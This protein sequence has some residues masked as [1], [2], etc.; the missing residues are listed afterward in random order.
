MIIKKYLSLKICILLVIITVLPLPGIEA[1]KFN[2]LY[3]ELGNKKTAVVMQQHVNVQNKTKF[4]NIK[5]INLKV[6]PYR[7][8]IVN[9][10][11]KYHHLSFLQPRFYNSD[12]VEELSLP[13]LK[14]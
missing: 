7:P 10:L 4:S 12:Y 3:G 14:H 2:K 11:P 8:L 5:N 13:G 9:M 6:K 1:E